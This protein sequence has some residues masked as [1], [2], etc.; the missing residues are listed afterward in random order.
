M[1]EIKGH[2]EDVY[3]MACNPALPENCHFGVVTPQQEMITGQDDFQ[4]FDTEE[5]LKQAVDEM[6][7]AGFYDSKTNI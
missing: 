4:T 5:E 3:F 7:G 1:H 6:N 2:T